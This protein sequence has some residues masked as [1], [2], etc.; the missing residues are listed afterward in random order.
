MARERS[1]KSA[2]GS[3]AP[4]CADSLIIDRKPSAVPVSFGY[5]CYMNGR[6]FSAGEETCSG[7]IRYQCEVDVKWVK[8]GT[9]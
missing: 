2:E 1:I 3:P 4:G 7:S 5:L 8:V 9:C 6:S